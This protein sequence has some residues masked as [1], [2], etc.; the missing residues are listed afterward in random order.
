M[1]ERI[2]TM[3]GPGVGKSKALLDIAK[4]FANNKE[5]AVVAKKAKLPDVQVMVYAIDPD[6]GLPPLVEHE[7]PEHYPN[8]E[9]IL[10]AGERPLVDIYEAVFGAWS[11]LGGSARQAMRDELAA[12]GRVPTAEDIFSLG[13]IDA[14]LAY[15]VQ[16]QAI[17]VARAYDLEVKAVRLPHW[18]CCEMLGRWWDFAQEEYAQATNKAEHIGQLLLQRKLAKIEN[19]REGTVGGFE[20]RSEWPIIKRMHKDIVDYLLLRS[21]VNL[22]AT[23]SVSDLPTRPDGSPLNAGASDILAAFSLRPEGEKHNLYLF[24]RMLLL[25]RTG[26]LRSM[27]IVKDRPEFKVDT[28]KADWSGKSFWEVYAGLDKRPKDY[29]P[30]WDV[31]KR[32]LKEGGK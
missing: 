3:G 17:A 30:G 31:T 19:P 9:H 14:G 16:A 1:R 27:V 26:K 29:L 18:I 23:T 5:W 24:D 20:G 8:F 12:K 15:W 22:Y 28:D 6:D 13:V 25:R 4:A 2:L 11:I 21:P 7:G 32:A 10:A